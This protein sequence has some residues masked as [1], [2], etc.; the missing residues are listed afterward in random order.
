MKGIMINYRDNWGAFTKEIGNTP[1]FNLREFLEHQKLIHTDDEREDKGI[2]GYD[3]VGRG[4]E[5]TNYR[6]GV[7][8]L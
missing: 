4:A 3:T 1:D 5:T 2:L 7:P 6:P 8:I